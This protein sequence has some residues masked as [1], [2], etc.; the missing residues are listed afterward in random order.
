MAT[1]TGATVIFLHSHPAWIAAQRLR[2]CAAK[3]C[4]GILRLRPGA[5]P[6][7]WRFA[8]VVR[9]FGV[10]PSA[11]TGVSPEKC[12]NPTYD[13]RRHITHVSDTAGGRRCIGQP[14][15]RVQMRCS[16]TLSP[17]ASRARAAAPSSPA[18]R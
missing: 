9:E 7:Q 14:N 15:R 17:H 4:I 5:V 18:H 10:H 6:R 11:T 1:T 16:T 8:A 3:R 12:Y 2:V 13:R